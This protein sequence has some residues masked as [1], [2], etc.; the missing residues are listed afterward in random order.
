MNRAII[1]HYRCPDDVVDIRLAG[2]ASKG[3]G[4]FRFGPE[5]ICYGNLASWMP[6]YRLNGTVYDA[7]TDVRIDDG[8]VYVP[9]DPDDVI[10]NLRLERYCPDGGRSA[11]LNLYYRL[12]P[13]LSARVRSRLQRAR[14]SDW[15]AIGFPR[16]PVDRTVECLFGQL[17]VLAMRAQGIERVPFVWFWPD[18]ATSCVVMTHDVEEASGRDFCSQLMDM[19]DGIGIKS[20]FQ[21]VPEER[22]PVP[23]SFLDEMRGRGFEINVHDLNHDGRLFVDRASFLR[24]ASRINMFG[25]RYGALGFRSGSLYRNQAWYGAL[26]F[27]YD[28]SVPNVAHL[29]PQRGGCCTVMPYFIGRILELPVTTIQDYSLFHILNDYSIDLWKQQL[30]AISN[31]HGLAAFIVHPDYIIASRA[32]ATYEELLEHL[33]CMREQRRTWI[34]LPREVA[35]WWRDRSRLR[36]VADKGRWRIEGEGKERARLAFAVLVGDSLEFGLEKAA[37]A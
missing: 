32:R 19:D 30:E 25:R 31:A 9:F 12:R 21:I 15:K 26:E 18:A 8:S 24:R 13:F 10:D 7:A 37:S 3:P 4:Y 36:V 16:W 27:S 20:S 29:D 34:T 6:S 17:L 14:L 23:D 2:N 22:Y 11:V 33:A 1:D 28:M 35:R 5:T